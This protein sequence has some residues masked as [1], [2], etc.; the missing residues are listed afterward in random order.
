MRKNRAAGVVLVVCA[1]VAWAGGAR[2][3]DGGR[4]GRPARV[5]PPAVERL[6]ADL[7]SADGQVRMAATRQLFDRGKAVLP[8][9]RKAGAKQVAPFPVGGDRRLDLVYSLLAGLPPSPPG[10]RAGYKRDS[11]GLHLTKGT[12]AGAVAHMGARYGFVRD[13]RFA[14]ESA[15]NCYVKLAPGKRLEEVIQRLLTEEPRVTTVNLNYFEG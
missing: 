13:G 14:A 5:E 1:G 8:A 11:L 10:G 9:L 7:D 2:S 4:P 12:T 6:I 15:P 3:E